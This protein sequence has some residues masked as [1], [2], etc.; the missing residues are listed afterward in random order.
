M[1]TGTFTVTDQRVFR[2]FISYASEDLAIATAVASCFKTALPDFFAEINIDRDFL[3]PGSAFKTQIESKLQQTDVLVIVY[4]GAE[5]ASHGYTGWEVGYFD[6][7]MRTDPGHRKKISL[8]LFEP[9]AITAYEQGIS[10]GLSTSQLRVSLHDFESVLSVSP[11]EALCSEIAAWQDEVAKNIEKTGFP[12]PHRKPEQEPA[13]CVHNL[14]LAIFQYLKGTVENTVKPQKQI[15][16]RVRGSAL[17]ESNETLPMEAELRPLGAVNTGGSMKIFGLADEP[18][19]WKR[20]VELTAGQPFAE[21]WQD[22]ITR[23]VLSSFPDRVDVDNSQV[24]LASD[25][26][27]GYRVI[28]TTATRYYDDCCEYNLYFVEMLQRTDYGDK[29][30]TQLLK[31][32]ELVCRF[33]SM[34]LESKSDFRGENVSLTAPDQMPRL[35]SRLLKEL[36]LMHRD[37]QEA[38]LDRPGLW[39]SYIDFEH[40]KAIADAYRPAESKLRMIIHKMMAVGSQPALL[41]PLSKEMSD[42]LTAMQIAVRPENALLL[43]EMAAKLSE[44]VEHQDEV[45][46]PVGSRMT[47]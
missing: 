33:R 20:F 9:P 3:E 39:T 10:L 43:R 1:A 30:T 16:V 15:T 36:N 47:N 42:V 19:T 14:K 38:G 37:A 21:S 41:E 6:H 13:K 25:G 7:I 34:F 12:K 27:T 26:R 23:V 45:S 5:K 2:I 44:L 46:A 17:E 29:D 8:Y 35:A 11:E 31:G 40:F 18:I 28:L 22:A 32:L 24:I 4:T